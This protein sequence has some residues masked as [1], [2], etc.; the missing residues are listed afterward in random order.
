TLPSFSS[1]FFLLSIFTQQVRNCPT[2]GP[3]L[4]APPRI[5]RPRSSKP[6]LTCHMIREIKRAHSRARSILK[7]Q[8]TIPIIRILLTFPPHYQITRE[9]QI[10]DLTH[11]SCLLL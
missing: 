4:E 8:K 6:K 5:G 2:I 10:E 1:C 11:L 9:R 3:R 7:R